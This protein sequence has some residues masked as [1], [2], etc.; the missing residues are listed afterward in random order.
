M[1]MQYPATRM[2]RLQ[3][4]RQRV[5]LTYST[6]VSIRVVE[7]MLPLWHIDAASGGVVH[8]DVD[9]SGGLN[10]ALTNRPGSA[11]KRWTRGRG[12]VKMSA[13]IP[14]EKKQHDHG[15]FARPPYAGPAVLHSGRDRRAHWEKRQND[16]ALGVRQDQMPSH[17]R[18]CIARDA[19]S[20]GEE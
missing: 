7:V 19:R 18:S 4:L 10:R 8:P 6:P 20:E 16:P 11:R 3:R 17:R 14:S 1:P 13:K 5:L 12:K 9:A 2:K 15:R